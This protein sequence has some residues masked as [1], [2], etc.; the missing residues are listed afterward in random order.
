MLR[1]AIHSRRGNAVL[2]FLGVVYAV[3]AIVLLAWHV[4]DTWDAAGMMDRLIQMV[5]LATLVAGLWFAR[6]AF[7]NLGVHPEIRSKSGH[8]RRSDPAPV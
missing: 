1:V 3:A 6:I 8:R 2:G 4:F 5:L 7:A